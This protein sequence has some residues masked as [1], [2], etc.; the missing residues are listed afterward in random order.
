RVRGIGP[1]SSDADPRVVIVRA[2]SSLVALVCALAA[3]SVAPAAQA[4]GC[5]PRGY[6][7]AG[8]EVAGTA[9]H[10][11]GATLTSVAT[12][13]VQHGHVAGW[14][15]VGGPSEGPGG[16]AEWLQV[17]LNTPSQVGGRQKLYYE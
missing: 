3:F 11:I 15:G 14:V 16:T 12:P 17:G 2:S 5:G 4:A 1:R 9:G 13:V 10:G 7:W 8:L 6:A